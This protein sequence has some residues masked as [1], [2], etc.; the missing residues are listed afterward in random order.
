MFQGKFLA[1]GST[2][3]RNVQTG[4]RYIIAQ[5]RN[6]SCLYRE[7]QLIAIGERAH[8]VNIIE[9]DARGLSNAM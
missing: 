6:E 1:D 7:G 3:Y 9:V 8:C 4:I 2:F 5:W